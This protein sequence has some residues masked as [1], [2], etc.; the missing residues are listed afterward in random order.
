MFLASLPVSP[1]LV[2]LHALKD[3]L[4]DAAGSSI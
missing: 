2:L 3:A 4:Q 1:H